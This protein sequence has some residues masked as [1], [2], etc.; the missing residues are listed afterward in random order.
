MKYWLHFELFTALTLIPCLMSM[1]SLV[2][3]QWLTQYS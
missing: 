2:W 1:L 3:K